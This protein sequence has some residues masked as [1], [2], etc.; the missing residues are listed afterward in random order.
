MLPGYF[1]T[2]EVIGSIPVARIVSVGYLHGPA[3]ERYLASCKI[4]LRSQQ[5]PRPPP[6]NCDQFHRVYLGDGARS[7]EEKS[8][9]S[10]GDRFWRG[11]IS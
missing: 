7:V 8:F 10:Y 2:V 4:N 9:G 1:D 5:L 11:F 6:A 3:L